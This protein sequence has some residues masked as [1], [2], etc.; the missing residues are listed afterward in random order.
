[1]FPKFTLL[2]N[3]PRGK[4]IPNQMSD[5]HVSH[6]A[7]AGLQ[8]KPAS[9]FNNQTERCDNDALAMELSPVFK[10]GLVR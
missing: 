5:I 2:L 7:D 8:H 9:E 4:V 6:S 3:V 1:M 10:S